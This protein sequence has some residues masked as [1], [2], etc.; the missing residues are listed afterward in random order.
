MEET[1]RAQFEARS[2]YLAGVHIT[3]CGVAFINVK[4]LPASKP[5]KE[6]SDSPVSLSLRSSDAVVDSPNM[7]SCTGS[8]GPRSSSSPAP[9][10]AVVS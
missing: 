10:S 4:A 1:G 6:Q 8:R 7:S 9:S 2:G 5:H 3:R